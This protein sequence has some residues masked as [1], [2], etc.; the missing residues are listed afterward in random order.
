MR[1]GD[2]DQDQGAFGTLKQGGGASAVRLHR[3]SLVAEIVLFKGLKLSQKG[4][5]DQ[6][7]AGVESKT[8]VDRETAKERSGIFG[9]RGGLSGKSDLKKKSSRRG[10]LHRNT[11]SLRDRKREGTSLDG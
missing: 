10:G 4:K 1:S 7:M 8:H 6:G 2:Q 11:A 5:A 3:I 9:N